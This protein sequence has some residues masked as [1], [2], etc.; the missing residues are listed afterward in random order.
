[1]TNW[2]IM[3]GDLGK[4]LKRSID[5]CNDLDGIRKIYDNLKECSIYIKNE[6]KSNVSNSVYVD[7]LESF[8]ED[9]SMEIPDPELDEKTTYEHESNIVDIY[10]EQFY[11]Y[12]DLLGV[13]ISE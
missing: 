10:L 5:E 4:E 11:D 1:M 7:D 13:W 8:I 6:M 12:C 9:L 3:L 2:K